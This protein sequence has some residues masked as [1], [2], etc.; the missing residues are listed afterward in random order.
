MPSQLARVAL[1]GAVLAAPIAIGIPV[2]AMAAP[3]PATVRATSTLGAN[4]GI[5]DDVTVE[6]AD[7][8]L[9]LRRD[10][11]D[12]DH[13]RYDC[14]LVNRNLVGHQI[15][16]RVFEPTDWSNPRPTQPYFHGSVT[17]WHGNG[18]HDTEV[19]LQTWLGWTTHLETVHS[20][21]TY[22]FNNDQIPATQHE[23]FGFSVEASDFSRPVGVTVNLY[24]DYR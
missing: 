18:T 17:S 12:P 23:G 5:D 16:F 24:R 10:T 1:L 8:A 14:S 4:H 11:G 22:L 9:C 2:S 13:L 7:G 19:G 15:Q 3:P 6:V 20:N 21:Q